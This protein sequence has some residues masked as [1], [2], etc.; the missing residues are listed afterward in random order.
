MGGQGLR[1]L[2]LG[3]HPEG[4]CHA[5]AW[6]GRGLVGLHQGT[7]V[8]SELLSIPAGSRGEACCSPRAQAPRGWGRGCSSMSS[9]SHGM[10]LTVVG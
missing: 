9:G 6:W 5:G 4:C 10:R 3:L 8:G 2:G 1:A 7:P